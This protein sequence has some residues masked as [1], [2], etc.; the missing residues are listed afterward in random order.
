MPVHATGTSTKPVGVDKFQGN[1][2][3]LRPAGDLFG[4]PPQLCV[5][6]KPVFAAHARVAGE[7]DVEAASITG[8]AGCVRHKI[9]CIAQN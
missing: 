5:V 4:G 8:G 2:V 6:V 3:Q 7:A 1:I 9:I